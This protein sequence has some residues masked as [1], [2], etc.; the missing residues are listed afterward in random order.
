VSA[1]GHPAVDPHTSPGSNSDTVAGKDG[2]A[3][4]AAPPAEE[5]GT[6]PASTPETP[7]TDATQEAP[8]N[9]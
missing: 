2:V 9:G 6:D 3:P 1:E 4:E 7:V 5:P 8:A